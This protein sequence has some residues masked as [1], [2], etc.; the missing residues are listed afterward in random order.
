RGELVQIGGGFRIPEILEASGAVL[1]EVGTTNRTTLEDYAAAVGERTALILKVH[2]SNFFMDGFVESPAIRDLVL[3]ARHKGLPLVED[4]GSGAVVDTTALGLPEREPSPAASLRAGVDLV[5]FSGDKLLGGPQAGIIA[6]K[7]ALVGALKREPFFRAL[8]CDKLILA[9]LQATVETALGAVADPARGPLAWRLLAAPVDTLRERARVLAERLA[10]A[11]LEA[12]VREVRG[13][14][15][16]GTLPRSELASVAVEVRAPEVRP[17]ELA[18]R[19][20]AGDPPVIGV[21]EQ[22]AVR[23]DLRTVPPEQDA[24]LEEAVLAAR[25]RRP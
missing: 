25:G 12:G 23:L 22:D 4:L 16:G 24:A 7:A 15:G 19:L 5:C 18:A 10:G 3:L 6:G 9:A 14:V 20:R 2:R 11:G 8:R 21:I 13:R 17:E 1:R